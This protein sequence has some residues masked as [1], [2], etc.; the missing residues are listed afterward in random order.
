MSPQLTSESDLSWLGKPIDTRPLFESELVSLLDLLRALRPADW[1]RAAVPGW[2]VRELAA[3]ILGDHQGRL[4]WTTSGYQPTFA[5]GET[6][7]AFIHRVNQEWVDLHI[8]VDPA[9]LIEALE[10]AG[11]QVARQFD[12]A[13][14]ETEGLGV[15]W[16]G[17]MPA[18]KWLDIARE[19]TEYWTHRQ[20][21]H[22]ATGRDTDS[23]PRALS[24]VL[25]TF[26]R[27]LPHTLRDDSAT[28]GTQVQVVV[29]GPAGGIWTTTATT[30]RW[31][32]AEAPAGRPAA[33]V[34]LNTETAWRLCTR[35]IEPDAALNRTRIRGDH[36]LAQ[37]VLQIVSIVY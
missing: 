1:D 21:I 30:N 17:A 12:T 16:A 25:D 2:T 27:A 13:D 9:S 23:E 4:G 8:D 22:H 36:K 31:S 18:P 3:H 35:G 33:S 37:A 24:A 34:A 11:T 29:D 19:F 32:M 14:L 15:S 5:P 6:L 28:P 7:E 20:Q 26:M 10:R